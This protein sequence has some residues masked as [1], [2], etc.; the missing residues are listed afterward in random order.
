MEYNGA[1]VLSVFFAGLSSLPLVRKCI[2]LQK[3]SDEMDRCFTLLE[4]NFN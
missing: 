2:R 1:A 4:I 3:S